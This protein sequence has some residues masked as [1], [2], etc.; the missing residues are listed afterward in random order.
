MTEKHP[1]RPLVT[2]GVPVYNEAA[3]LEESLD[4]FLG[5]DYPNLEIV[6]SDNGST[7]ATPDICRKAA[8]SDPRVFFHRFPENRGIA[9]NFNKLLEMAGGEY[10]AWASGHDL[11]SKNLAS[12]CERLLSTHP[13]ASLAFASSCWIDAGGRPLKREYGWTDTRGMDAMARFFAV[14]WGN[15]HPILGLF[16]LDYLRRIPKLTSMAG[17]DLLILAELSLLGDFLHAP[18]ALLSRRQPRKTETHKERLKRYQKA[19]FGLSKSALDR[20]APLARLPLEL[21]KVVMR[22]PL[23]APDK[24]AVIGALAA[25]FPV[26]YIA[27]RKEAAQRLGLD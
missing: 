17:T 23:S 6:I 3:F 9:A 7:D 10:F 8:K 19:D 27:G 24:A 5:Q 1:P 14:L 13:G 15:V 2:I 16:R 12:A 25:A 21:V 26:R 22:S 20:V 18:E 4:S 11:W